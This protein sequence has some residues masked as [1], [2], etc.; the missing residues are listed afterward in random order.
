VQNETK[1]F[2]GV[3][4]CCALLAASIVNNFI[5]R[6]EEGWALQKFS[7]GSVITG[8]CFIM[9]LVVIRRTEK[10]LRGGKP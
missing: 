8:V 3:K 2:D 6:G 4:T 9:L 5:A 7:A 1:I 10:A